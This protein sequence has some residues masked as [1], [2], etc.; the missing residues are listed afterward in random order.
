MQDLIHLH[1]SS[2]RPPTIL[3]KEE[4]VLLGPDSLWGSPAA[5]QAASCPLQHSS[6]SLSLSLSRPV[7]NLLNLREK[8]SPLTQGEF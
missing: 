5:S 4:L 3:W 7:L 8:A 6:L 1:V 2:S